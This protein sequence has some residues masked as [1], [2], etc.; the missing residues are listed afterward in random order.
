[1]RTLTRLAL[2]VAILFALVLPA[3]LC[4]QATPPDSITIVFRNGHRQ[5]IPLA[6]I[7][8]IEF[9]GPVPADLIHTPGP[10]RVHYYGRW[11]VG[12]G[13]GSDFFII[14]REDGTAVRVMSGN[15]VHGSWQYVNGEALITWDDNNRDAI[16]KI[17]ADFRKF[18][19]ENGKSFTDQPDNITSAHNVTLNPSGVD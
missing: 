7:D 5:T 17:G 6:D 1:M 9:P 2:C 11:E 4:A 15:R 8:R 18:A 3:A 12:D 16:R 10:S 14:L 13:G 19:Y